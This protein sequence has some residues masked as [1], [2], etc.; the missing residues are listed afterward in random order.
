MTPETIF[1]RIAS[2]SF[3][4]LNE[5][6]TFTLDRKLNEHGIADLD[7]TDWKVRLLGIR[8]LARLGQTEP[9]QTIAEGLAHEDLHVRQITAA[10][11]GILK[12]STSASRLE[13]ALRQDPSP[14]VRAQAAMA[15]GQ[16]QSNSSLSVLGKALDEDSSRD[17]RHQCELA[18]HQI[19]SRAG[20][21][22]KQLE[23]FL[24]LETKDFHTL[25]V[26]APAPEFSLDST[27]GKSWHLKTLSRDKWSVLIWIFADWCPVCHNEFHELIELESQFRKEN[28]GVFT[29]E[30]HDDYRG[31]VM[32]GKE[33]EPD[34]WFSEESLKDAYT[35]KIWWPHLL[36]RGGKV[37]AAYGVD[38]MAFAVHAEY[39][40]RPSVVIIDPEGIIRLAYYGTYWGDRPSM[41]E[42]LGMIRAEDF[43]FQHPKRLTP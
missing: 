9:I 40:N 1:Q 12:A 36:D 22:S 6:G 37:G 14:L 5:E 25:E 30:I 20:A 2:H 3:H 33:L 28:I 18:I 21:T 4:P 35:G 41:R 26:G 16:M 32:V 19:E 23:A 43:S 15:L 42:I 8:D 29:L 27:E 10:A 13:A 17:V 34:Y 39:I 7:D 11:L 38:P 31:N 24:S